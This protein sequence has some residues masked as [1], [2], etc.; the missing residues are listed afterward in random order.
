MESLLKT[1]LLRLLTLLYS[2]RRPG[3]HVLTSVRSIL[4]VRQHDQLGDMLCVIPLLRALKSRFV[5]AGVTLVTSPVNHEIM[6]HNSVGADVLLYDKARLRRSPLALWRFFR[7]LRAPGHDLAVVPVTVSTSTTSDLIALLSGAGVRI[8]PQSLA[9]RPNPGGRCYT[10]P[11]ELSWDDDPRRHQTLRNL[12]II[13]SLGIGRPPLTCEIGL[14][15]AE[16]EEAAARIAP[17][18][19]KHE[20]V[21]GIHPGAG[22]PMNR[23][24][25]DRFAL[26][27]DRIA[28]NYKAAILVTAGPRDDEPLE[29]FCH[30]LESSYDLFRNRPVRQLAAVLDQIDLYLTNDTGVMHI[31]GGVRTRVLSLFGP[32]DPLQWAPAGEK[33]R[34]IAATDGRM[35]S[36]TVEEVLAVVEVIL[37]E[38]RRH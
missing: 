25:A 31:A 17:L 36:I 1:L 10:Q 13:A 4:V 26:V 38:R 9:G 14:T 35:S 12:D 18:R 33:N 19:S 2:P 32:T 37:L 3:E 27:A 21:V 5:G 16:R 20:V 15:G 23:W 8:G 6:L 7:D 28:A 29:Q 34:Y 22:K 24:P 11:I 30:H